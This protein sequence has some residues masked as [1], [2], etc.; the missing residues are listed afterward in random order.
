MGVMREKILVVDDDRIIVELITILL[1]DRGFEVATANSGEA[2]LRYFD[3]AMPDLVV[4]DY[5]MPGM[6]GLQALREIK[7]RAPTTHV[8]ILTGRGNEEVAVELMK[9][10]ASDYLSKP[11]RN[12]NLL[13]RVDGVLRLRRIE[14][15]NRELVRE[16]ERL[17]AEITAWNQELE[18]R[19]EEKTRELERA[20]A[21]IIQVEKLAALGHL[22]AGLAHEIRNP[23]NSINLFSQILKESLGP[24]GENA[25]F[26]ERIQSEVERI[27]ALLVRLLAASRPIRQQ[28]APVIPGEIA[29]AEVESFLPQFKAQQIALELQIADTPSILGDREELRQIFSNLI[30]NALHSMPSGG[31]LALRVGQSGESLQFVISDSGCGIPQEHLNRIFDP[32]FT[33][34]TKGTGFGLSVVLR[35]VKTYK[36]RIE[37]ESEPGAGTTFRIVLPLNDNQG[38]PAV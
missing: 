19:V 4:M 14:Q 25:E 15:H 27:D 7:R 8:I 16:R 36:G 34:R 6:D 10:G 29:R 11:F 21:E 2:C 20:Q 23:L 31:K 22:V 28:L 9:A 17:Q 32:F 3:T 12:Q 13:D 37:V 24:E 38:E 33:T 35:I 18:H 5:L 30:S 26:L 1:N